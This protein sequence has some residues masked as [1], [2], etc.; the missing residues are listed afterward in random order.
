MTEQMWLRNTVKPP[1]RH[2]SEDE[3][4][5]PS[6]VSPWNK[7]ILPGLISNRGSS[8]R[9]TPLG[10]KASGERPL[11]LKEMMRDVIIPAGV[12]FDTVKWK[13]EIE[14]E[15]D[16]FGR[17]VLPI[18]HPI[19]RSYSC[20]TNILDSYPNGDDILAV[21]AIVAAAGHI[22]EKQGRAVQS[23]DLTWDFVAWLA[24]K[25]N[26]DLDQIPGLLEYTRTQ[27]EVGWNDDYVKV[28]ELHCGYRR[29]F[30]TEKGYLGLGPN[31]IETGDQVCILFG[32][33]TPFIL[34]KVEEHYKLIGEAYIHGIMNGEIVQQWE[35]GE[36][37][38]Q[39]FEIR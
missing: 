31:K 29:F 19:V 30:I 32:G 18:D 3:A 24:S 4:S 10:Y 17:E 8:Y 22:Q 11:K 14:F 39:W 1:A 7:L 38:E 5:F 27:D 16:F 20:V 13:C 33:K 35:A 21:F 25:V 15:A 12:R 2:G 28:V 34:R 36:L 23:S 26:L 37:S 9:C 6:W